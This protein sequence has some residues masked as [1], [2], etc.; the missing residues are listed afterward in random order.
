[1]IKNIF[2]V[3]TAI[4]L[5]VEFCLLFPATAFADSVTE[6]ALDFLKSKQ[7]VT[8]KINTGFSSPSEWSAIAFALSGIDISTVKKSDKSLKDFLSVDVPSDQAPATDW[9]SRILAVVATGQ[10]PTNFGG[11]N[12]VKRLEGFY[13]GGQI[14]DTCS[15]N[16]DI[17][18][19]FALIASGNSSDNQIKKDVLNFIIQKQD[20]KDG[21]FGFSAPGCSFYSTSADMTGA[22]VQVLKLAKTN[23]LSNPD[24]DN[25]I[26]KAKNYLLANQDPDGG[27]GY[28]GSSDPDT[29]G[30][31]LMAF[32]S[33]DLKDSSESAKAKNWLISQQ[34]LEDGGIKAFDYSSNLFVSNATTTAQAIIALSGKGWVTKIFDTNSASP[35]SPSASFSPAPSASPSLTPA[36]SATPLATSSPTIQA[37]SAS[38]TLSPTPV[39]SYSASPTPSPV[40]TPIPKTLPENGTDKTI[41]SPTPSPE[42]LGTSILPQQNSLQKSEPEMNKPTLV[43]G[44]KTNAVP[45]FGVFGLFSAFKILEERRWKK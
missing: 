5:S 41:L 40:F 17:F 44:F 24:L 22:A 27:F 32:N 29:T 38:T 13:N 42:V 14:G 23:S 19:L 39:P 43:D 28:F 21:G 3:I 45:L 11:K 9:E 4:V 18:G 30:W 35:A 37:N 36:P 1:M 25:A 20:S 31:V 2:F 15:L 26:D 33:L 34:S 8:G 6:K 16:D 12:M 10:D 7:D